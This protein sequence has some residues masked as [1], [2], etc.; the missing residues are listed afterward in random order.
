FR[1]DAQGAVDRILSGSVGRELADDVAAA[2]KAGAY[3]AR[4]DAANVEG[5]PG[6]RVH[7]AQRVEAEARRELLAAAVRQPGH[8]DHRGTD[9]EQGA[10]RKV[11][12]AEIE[13]HI[14]LITGERPPL[15]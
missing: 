14:E 8:L 15:T 4:V 6:R 13:V 2:D 11:V 3:D 5:V 12:T 1:H 9:L 7:E 10:G